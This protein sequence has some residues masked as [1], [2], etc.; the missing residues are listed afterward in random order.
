MEPQLEIHKK[1]CSDTGSY[2]YYWTFQKRKHTGYTE[3][4]FYAEGKYCKSLQDCIDDWDN[5][6]GE[7]RHYEPTPEDFEP[8]EGT[9]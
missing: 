5:F 9:C 3:N 8:Y 6:I 1:R 4:L 7:V 2:T